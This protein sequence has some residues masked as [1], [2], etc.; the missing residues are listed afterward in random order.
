MPS[1][2]LYTI[3]N[4]YIFA[5]LHFNHFMEARLAERFDDEL[6]FMNL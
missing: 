1:V 3:E 5:Y 2:I 4:V 6:T